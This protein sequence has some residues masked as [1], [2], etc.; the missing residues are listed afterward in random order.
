MFTFISNTDG[1][2]ILLHSLTA[3]FHHYVLRDGILRR[4]LPGSAGR[5]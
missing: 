2:T 5:P 1:L 4:M 3:L